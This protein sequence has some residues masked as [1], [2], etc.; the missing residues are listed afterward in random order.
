ME[1]C[2]KGGQGSP[3][4]VALTKK[5]KKSLS[6]LTKKLLWKEWLKC[7]IK[8]YNT[9][10]YKIEMW[11]NRRWHCTKFLTYINGWKQPIFNF[12]QLQL[13]TKLFLIFKQTT[14]LLYKVENTSWSTITT[15]VSG[16]LTIWSDLHFVSN[17]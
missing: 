12:L 2:D 5:K 6:V 16:F 1:A 8:N 7:L 3:R 14:T 13:T 15:V 17:H 10:S 9:K 4:T 11:I